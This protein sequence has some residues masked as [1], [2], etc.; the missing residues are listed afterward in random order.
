MTRKFIYDLPICVQQFFANTRNLHI[1][2]QG[3]S[4][5]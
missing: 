2:K 5:E 3:V 1:N 4:T